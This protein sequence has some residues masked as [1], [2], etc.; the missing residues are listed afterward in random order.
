[1]SVMVIA[2]IEAEEPHEKTVEKA[3]RDVV[4]PSRDDDGCEM[5]VLTR[6]EDN[7]SLF[8]MVERWRDGAALKAHENT[9]HYKALMNAVKG[10][11]VSLDIQKLDVRM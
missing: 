9:P 1:M 3:L 6:D 5:Y 11:L 8:L 4:T 7:T 10:K 2:T